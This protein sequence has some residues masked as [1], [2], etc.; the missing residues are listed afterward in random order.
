[1]KRLGSLGAWFLWGALAC[2]HAAESMEIG[3]GTHRWHRDLAPAQVDRMLAATGATSWRD[4]INWAA[5]ERQRGVYTLPAQFEALMRAAG[6]APARGLRPLVIVGYG[7]PLYETGGLV[8]TDAARKGFAAYARWLAA[9]LKG[10]V[11]YYEIWNEWNIGTGSTAM[12][13]A[14]GSVDDYARLV[15]IAAAAIRAVDP[16]ARIIAGGATNHD[17]GWFDAFGRSGALDVIDGVSI[18]PYNYGRPLFAH[19]PEAAIAWVQHIQARL[20]ARRGRPVTMYITEIGWP[21]HAGGYAPAQ[22]ADYLERFMRL[23]RRDPHIAGVWW[24]DLVNDGDDA[25]DPEHHFGLFDRRHRPLPALR[26]LQACC[27]KRDA[28]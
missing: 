18:H 3:V 20:S 2:V 21:A 7:N 19:T 17:T 24:Y 23:A 22:V 1:M 25:D 14:I 11:R 13:R 10:K 4:G 15:R 9:R 28:P 6:E 5:V 16:Q 27:G 8:T 26:A 12:P